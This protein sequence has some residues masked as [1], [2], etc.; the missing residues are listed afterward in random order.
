MEKLTTSYK[1]ASFFFIIC[2][3][4]RHWVSIVLLS[5]FLSVCTNECIYCGIA[6]SK[7]ESERAELRCPFLLSF[8]HTPYFFCNFESAFGIAVT[9]R[10]SNYLHSHFTCSM[11]EIF[12][13]RFFPYCLEF[14][15]FAEQILR[16]IHKSSSK[17]RTTGDLQQQWL[18]YLRQW[19]WSVWA[20]CVHHRPLSCRLPQ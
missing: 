18:R 20:C 17:Q 13:W 11:T 6:L 12:P 8:F 2:V 4:V 19:W 5:V 10:H 3:V 1:Y 7:E 14:H 15:S 16:F 9:S